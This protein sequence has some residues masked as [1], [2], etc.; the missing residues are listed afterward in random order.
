MKTKVF[1]IFFCIYFDAQIIRNMIHPIKGGLPI[2][3]LVLV[4][5]S[6][7]GWYIFKSFW[8]E[9]KNSEALKNIKVFFEHG[10][11]FCMIPAALLFVALL[12]RTAC[13]IIDK[14]LAFE[15]IC[16]YTIE[17]ICICTIVV[18]RKYYIKWLRKLPEV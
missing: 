4:G 18:Y 2:L 15:A 8:S 6:I 11:I 12:E 1:L 9:F 13:A 16:L 10:R 7:L 17:L 14:S 5:V 3:T